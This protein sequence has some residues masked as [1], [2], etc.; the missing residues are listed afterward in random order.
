VYVIVKMKKLV[1]HLN[2]RVRVNRRKITSNGN[3]REDSRH[4]HHLNEGNKDRNQDQQ[5]EKFFIVTGK[6]REKL[7]KKMGHLERKSCFF[8]LFFTI[9]LRN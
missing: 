8:G 9:F 7:T 1:N 4:P 3:K 2:G 5:E 6:D